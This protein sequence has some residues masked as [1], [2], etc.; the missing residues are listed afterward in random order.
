MVK[1]EVYFTI[2]EACNDSVNQ[3]TNT[4]VDLD[5]DLEATVQSLQIN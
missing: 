2:L 3:F 5:L 1:F 4:A